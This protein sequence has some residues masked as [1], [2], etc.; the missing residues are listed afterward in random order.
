MKPYKLQRLLDFVRR[1]TTM[2]LLCTLP[3]LGV[4]LWFLTGKNIQNLATIGLVL[5]CPLSHLFLMNHG[6][7]HHNQPERKKVY[8]EKSSTK[9][10]EQH[11]T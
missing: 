10:G 4:L 7:S 1:H 9:G 11:E 3:F 8:P 2:S 6:N 5:A